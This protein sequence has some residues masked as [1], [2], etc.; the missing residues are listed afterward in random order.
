MKQKK[1]ISLP[2]NEEKIYKQILA[3]FGFML[4]ITSQE[5]DILAELIKLDNEYEVLPPDKRGKFILS[6][7]MRKEIQKKLDIKEKQFNVLIHKLKNDP[8]KYF[9]GKPLI[10]ENN[11][12]HPELKWKPDSEGFS[13]EINFVMTALPKIQ[14]VKKVEV[15]ENDSPL[16][17]STTTDLKPP[18][19]YQHDASK[20]PV[21]E[22]ETFDFT[23]TVPNE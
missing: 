4:N 13:I 16:P 18:V 21:I 15:E 22:E 10:D 20:A 23:I 14:E 1:I 11:L 8:K 9:L 2:T 3:F 5:R 19:E 12:I 17:S 6:T 7:D